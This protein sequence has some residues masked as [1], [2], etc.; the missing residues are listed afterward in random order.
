MRTYCTEVTQLKEQL[1]VCHIHSKNTSEK[2]TGALL[3]KKE[4]PQHK[5]KKQKME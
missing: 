4:Q 3:F 2:L 5:Y 1:Q